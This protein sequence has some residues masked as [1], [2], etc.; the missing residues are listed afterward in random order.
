MHK[1]QFHR[2][3]PTLF[4]FMASRW[5]SESAAVLSALSQGSAPPPAT[6]EAVTLTA[7]ILSSLLC[8][9]IPSFANQPGAFDVLRDTLSLLS[10]LLD[11][12]RSLP[13]AIPFLDKYIL[14]LAKMYGVILERKPLE[15]PPEFLGAILEFYAAQ[16]LSVTGIS[17]EAFA[18]TTTCLPLF[19]IIQ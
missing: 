11:L 13:S 4:S 16:I 9:G 17:F 18:S 6:A 15:I 2:I 8:Y 5:H 1:F 19:I 7:K 14:R 12:K 3:A 10:H